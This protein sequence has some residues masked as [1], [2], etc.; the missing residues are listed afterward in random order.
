[1]SIVSTTTS[2]VGQPASE[3]TE[4]RRTLDATVAR[5]VSTLR[6]APSGTLPIAGMHWRVGELGAHVAQ[7]ATVFTQATRGETTAYGEGGEFNAQVD[8]QLVDE[9][10]ERDPARLGTLVEERYVALRGAFAARRDDEIVPQ[11]QGYS[12]AG[13][14]AIWVLDLNVHGYQIGQSARRPFSV[15]NQAIRLALATVV[16]FAVDPDGAR[17]MHV[18]YAM[19]IKGTPPLVYTVDD[20]AVLVAPTDARVDCHLGVDP[21]AFLLVT[22]GVMPQWRATATLKMR[23]WGRRPWLAG[24]IS[25]LFPIVPHGGIARG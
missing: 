2:G 21:V 17:G 24:R 23:A 16:P 6:S 1:M 10:G 4:I 3:T 9:L 20:G 14:N 19:H 11:F 25:K 15:D 12:I 13:I 8:Q 22:L 18:T 7:T 5:F